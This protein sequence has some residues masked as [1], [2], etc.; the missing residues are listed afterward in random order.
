MQYRP[1]ALYWPTLPDTDRLYLTLT[2]FAST[3]FHTLDAD[4]ARFSNQQAFF[5]IGIANVG[6]DAQCD[7]DC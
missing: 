1:H 7:I 5:H 2:D 6:G 4:D 3:I